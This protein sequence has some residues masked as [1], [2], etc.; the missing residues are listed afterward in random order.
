MNIL[1][2]LSTAGFPLRPVAAKDRFVVATD[3]FVRQRLFPRTR[4]HTLLSNAVFLSRR[5]QGGLAVFCPRSTILKSLLLAALAVPSPLLAINPEKDIS[6]YNHRIWLKKDGLPQNSAIALAQT[7]DGFIWVGTFEGLARFDGLSFKTYNPLNTPALE[8]KSMSSLHVTRDGTLW[9]GIDMAGL[10]TMRKGVFRRISIA[11][12]E[13]PLRVGGI[14]EDKTGRVWVA[15]SMALIALRGDSVEKAYTMADGLRTS[16]VYSM[17]E[18]SAGRFI[19]ASG[20]EL[21]V[22]DNDRFSPYPDSRVQSLRIRVVCGDREG[23]LWVGTFDDGVAHVTSGGIQRYRTAE[24]LASPA[25]MSL[26][27]DSRGALWVGTMGG[28][29][30][31]IYREKISTYTAKS[32]LSGDDVSPLLE[33]RE[34]NLWV[35]LPTAGLN[36]FVEGKFTTFTTGSTGPQNF[37]YSLFQDRS[38]ALLA[39][40]GSREVMLFDKG[41]FV[42]HPLFPRP[43]K[44]FPA[45][46]HRDGGN[47]LW[48]GTTGGLYRY[49]RGKE[50]HFPLGFVAAIR[51]AADG[52]LWFGSARGLFYFSGGRPVQYSAPFHG[53]LADVRSIVQDERGR[54]WI[55]TRNLG[56]LRF[57]PPRDLARAE[58]TPPPD[59]VWYAKGDGLGAD[60]VTSLLLDPGGA[61]WVTTA[62]GGIC[63]VRN[64]RVINLTYGGLPEDDLLMLVDDQRGSFW[65]SSNNGIF[66]VRRDDLEQYADGVRLSYPWTLFGMGAGMATDECNGAYES[67]GLRT[68]DGNVWFPTAA[69]AVMVN[70]D[71]L[72]SNVVPP[73]VVL[74]RVKIGAREVPASVPYSAPPG[75]GDLEFGFL[76]ISMSAPELVQFRVMLAGFDE[77]WVD[78]GTRRVCSYTNIAPGTYTFRVQA[79][80]ADGV[81]NEAGASFPLTIEPFFYQTTWFALICIV[82]V[83]M[84]GAGLHAAVQR[85]RDRQ[86]VAAQL[87]SQLARAQLRVLEMQVQPHF[88][89]NAL[90]GIGV[91]IREDPGRATRMLTR[92]SEFVRMALDRSGV[93]EISLREELTFVDRYLSIELLR[94]GDRLTVRQE[95]TDELLD[96]LVPTMILQPLVENAIRHGVSKRRGPVTIQIEATRENGTLNLRV[97]DDGPG[98]QAVNVETI[99][100]GIGLTNTRARLH[101][102]YGDAHTFELSSPPGGGVNVELAIPFHKEPGHSW[103]ASRR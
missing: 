99:R 59:L 93:Q 94:F 63:L 96:A 68:R 49:A 90:N 91:L 83:L 66:R 24:G 20:G 4:L 18:D 31:R 19:V 95:V 45:V 51:E 43:L 32:G 100:E 54:L 103:T 67:A 22:L 92:L 50:T 69:G 46:F 28:G 70:P 73:A 10:A 61:L 85:D 56:L 77:G 89:F 55:G 6:Q 2:T 13:D 97:R 34:G 17:T 12:P 36:S 35:G 65:L 72:P 87:E 81:W 41:R 5:P 57:T 79:R 27:L 26:L 53:E 101:Q 40:T 98:I 30:S 21:L 60:W 8:G 74:D 48:V 37:V 33:D 76:G 62:G 88:L 14:Y 84:A 86:L 23:G 102:L 47:R 7:P 42:P 78:V 75:D 52:T 3:R 80:N 29:V 1:R 11:K 25:I 16:Y 58:K 38:G 71:S 64:D 9:I 44:G 15:T 39:G 82:T